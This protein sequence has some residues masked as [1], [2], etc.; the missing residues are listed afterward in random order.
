MYSILIADD[1]RW[2]RSSLKK[3]IERIELP[4]KLSYEASHGLEVIDF[5]KQ[6]HAD[7]IITDICMPIMDG[8]QLAQTIHEQQF[9]T[10]IIIVSGHDEF[11]YAQ[12]AVKLG[13]R[14]YLL[15]PVLIEDVSAILTKI[16]EE[17]IF[18][19]LQEKKEQQQEN[20]QMIPYEERS[21]IE[22]VITFI[23]EKMPGEVTLQETASAVHLNSSY[24]SSLFKEQMKMKFMDYVMKVRMEEAQKL[25]IKTSLRVS[26]I[27]DRLEYNDIA[28]FSNT[29]KRIC[30]TTPS[31]YRRLHKRI[32]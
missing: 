17:R 28:Y 2:V 11:Q 25:L 1:E 4:F 19:K 5:L 12:Q 18:K 21:T 16:K 6:N 14:D 24:L 20:C 9:N 27:A 30:G 31:E 23:H 32:T 13:V 7:V 22:K 10:D 8:L 3:I 26:E 29:F 15:K